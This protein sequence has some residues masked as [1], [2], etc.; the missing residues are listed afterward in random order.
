[1][2]NRFNAHY[3]LN[4]QIHKY[5][6]MRQNT[7]IGCGSVSVIYHFLILFLPNY[8]WRVAGLAIHFCAYT[9][10]GRLVRRLTTSK[11]TQ[12]KSRMIFQNVIFLLVRRVWIQGS[13]RRVNG[14]LN[15]FSPFSLSYPRQHMSAHLFFESFQ[16]SPWSFDC[17]VWSLFLLY[18]F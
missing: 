10:F 12:P 18:K 15:F 13:Q 2:V 8:C 17:F 7:R 11:N 6:H 3:F 5:P 4:D 1:M 16:F 9:G 14:R